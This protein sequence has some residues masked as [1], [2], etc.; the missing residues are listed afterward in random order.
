MMEDLLILVDENDREIGYGKK[1]ETHVAGKLHRAFSVF[2]FDWKQKKMLL[3][4]RA[5]GKY[6]SG[7]LWS[8]ACCSH[9][10]KG[11]TMAVA[12]SRRLEEGLGFK[13]PTLEILEY[14]NQSV[15]KGNEFIDYAGKFHY[16]AQ[17]DGLAEHEID[18]VFLYYPNDE[19][20][21][22]LHANPEEV[23]ELRWVAVEELM[24]WMDECPADFSAWFR[25]AFDLMY[26]VLKYEEC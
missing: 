6:H 23:G 20:L 4:K 1:M 24:E 11:E 17:Y 18:H 12:L 22:Q 16:F 15:H 9:P 5:E 21:A 14:P 26:K 2:I 13:T 8:N 7:G 25:P 19:Q 3:Q 10:R